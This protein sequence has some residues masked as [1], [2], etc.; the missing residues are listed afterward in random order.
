MYLNE[1]DVEDIRNCWRCYGDDKVLAA[2][3]NA[4]F[5]PEITMYLAM[6]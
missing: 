2:L 5:L 6:P 3:L 1:D 4:K